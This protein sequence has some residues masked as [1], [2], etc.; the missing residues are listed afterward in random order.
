MQQQLITF[1]YE[2]KQSEVR[3]EKIS[4]ALLIDLIWKSCPGF[5]WDRVNFLSSGWYSV[6]SWIQCEK[7]VDNTLMFSVVAK[8]CLD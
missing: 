3:E 1:K 5:G 7:Y 2:V 4:K 8:Q 6:M